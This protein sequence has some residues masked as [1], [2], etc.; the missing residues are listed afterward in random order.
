MSA[1][2]YCDVRATTERL[3]AP[4]SPEDQCVQSMPDSSPTKWHLAHTSWFFET[5]LLDGEQPFDPAYRFLFNS[6]YEAVGPRYARPERGMITRPGV[7]DVARYR[8]NVDARMNALIERGVDAA[9]AP[10]VEL[11]LHHEQ[12]HQELIVMDIQHLF[13]R[14]PQFPGYGTLPWPTAVSGAGGGWRQ[15]DGG[16]V[17]VGCDGEGFAFDNEGPRH[18]VLLQPFEV[19]GSLVTCGEWLNFMTDGGYSRSELWM[20]EGWATAQAEGWRAPQYWHER[21]TDWWRFGLDGLG[22]V[23][24]ADA[25]VHVSWFEADAYAR[26]AGARLPSEAEW[27]AVAPA[28][29]DSAGPGWYGVVW[30]WTASPYTPY[31]G[32]RP[33]PSAVGEY[34]G[35]FMVNQHVLRGSCVA[36]PP[37]H[38]RRTYRNF[39]PARARWAFSGVRLTRDAT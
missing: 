15:H 37:G 26:W 7:A 38:G 16:I 19:S 29:D 2:T 35:K 9:T 23:N 36:T 3:A 5:F 21:D 13:S 30:Q 12:Q 28:P 33:A 6:Y 27:E 32:F 17:G 18:D 24:L 34:N 4:L 22:P 1:L 11:G 14:N 39:F 8:A 10:L 31:P 20:S 25:V